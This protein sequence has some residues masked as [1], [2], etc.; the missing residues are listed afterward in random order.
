MKVSKEIMKGTLPRGAYQ[1]EHIVSWG[2]LE[3]RRT[4]SMQ[5]RR[6]QPYFLPASTPSIPAKN[7]YRFKKK[8]KTILRQDIPTKMKTAVSNISFN[9]QNIK[10]IIRK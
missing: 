10:I 8:K 1:G 5:W 2:E 3:Q 9:V 4:T 7:K 6:T